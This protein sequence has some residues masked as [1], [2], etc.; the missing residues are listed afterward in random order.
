MGGYVS[1]G[2]QQGSGDITRV[3]VSLESGV[4]STTFNHFSSCL[5]ILF[6]F[7]MGIIKGEVAVVWLL[8][9]DDIYLRG[10]LKIFIVVGIGSKI[11][12]DR[13]GGRGGV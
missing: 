6:N 5:D 11:K 4:I 2:S 10:G 13:E 12:G 9:E 1:A 3:K 8:R 7:V